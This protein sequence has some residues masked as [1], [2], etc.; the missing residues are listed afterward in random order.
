VLELSR[1]R[2]I[3]PEGIVS[4]IAGSTE[5][6]VDGDGA[7]AKF[8]SPYGIGIDSQGNIWV[9]DTN[10]NRIRKISFE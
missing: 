7:S 1:I 2:K 4:T 9:A 10:N 6:Y 8:Y 3:S 5:G